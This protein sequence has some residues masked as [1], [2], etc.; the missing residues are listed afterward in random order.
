VSRI[1]GGRTRVKDKNG[2]LFTIVTREWIETDL[3]RPRKLSRLELET[4]E[5][6]HVIDA[7]T[8]LVIGTGKKLRR[9]RRVKEQAPRKS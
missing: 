5:R 4:G 3:G 7:N 1:R 8:F 9:V 2:G 6:V